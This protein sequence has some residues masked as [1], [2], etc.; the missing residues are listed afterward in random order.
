ML[1]TVGEGSRRL[2]W[3]WEGAASG[4]VEGPVWEVVLEARDLRGE[5]LERAKYQ[6][7]APTTARTRTMPAI[8]PGPRE[9][10]LRGP[11]E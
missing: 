6:T 10:F 7:A 3:T 8:L 2:R 4:L 11:V 5:A 1:M 9:D